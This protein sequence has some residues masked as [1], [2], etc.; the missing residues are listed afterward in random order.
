MQE[1]PERLGAKHYSTLTRW[2]ALTLVQRIWP[3]LSVYLA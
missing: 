3:M 2:Y 1:P